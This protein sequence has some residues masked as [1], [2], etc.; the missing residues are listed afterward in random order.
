MNN[1]NVETWEILEIHYYYTVVIN[2]SKVHVHF[3]ARLFKI[4]YGLLNYFFVAPGKCKISWKYAILH[5][6]CTYTRI[7]QKSQK[8]F[9]LKVYP[10]GL[11]SNPSSWGRSIMIFVPGSISSFMV[12]WISFP[13][14]KCDSNSRGSHFVTA[15]GGGFLIL[16]SLFWNTNNETGC[17][18]L[19]TYRKKIIKDS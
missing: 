9:T 13:C 16:N 4:A 18:E 2:R 5:M 10:S 17:N 12:H 3:V 11:L 19:G 1:S 14:D 7:R 15:D 6:I 8:K